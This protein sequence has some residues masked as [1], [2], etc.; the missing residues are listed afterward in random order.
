MNRCFSKEDIQMDNKH[1]EMMLIIIYH[2][3]NPSQNYNEISLISVR[4]ATINNTR[5]NRCWQECG[6]RGTLLYGSWECKL[7]TATLEN[8][9]EV[10]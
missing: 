1:N 8:S 10:P 7:G 6:E 4:M 9:M 3:G 2:R 5:D